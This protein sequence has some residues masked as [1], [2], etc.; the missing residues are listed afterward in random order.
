[1]AQ[2]NKENNFFQLF[3][4]EKREE[5]KDTMMVFSQGIVSKNNLIN[6][7]TSS[8]LHD[9]NLNKI[10]FSFLDQTIETELKSEIDVS[11]YSPH[12]M[13]HYTIDLIVAEFAWNQLQSNPSIP[14]LQKGT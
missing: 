2:E 11:D 5:L 8:G 4:R 9:V 6:T 12:E 1:M 7:F 3:N 13:Y 14:I 10:I